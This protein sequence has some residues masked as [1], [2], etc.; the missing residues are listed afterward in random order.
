MSTLKEALENLKAIG[1]TKEMTEEL[2]ELLQPEVRDQVFLDLAGT[3]TEE[4]ISQYEARADTIKTE[5]E[6]TAF[7][8]ELAK[9][10]Y[11]EGYKEKLEQI[12]AE[13]ISNAAELTKNA[14][15]TYQSYMA[16]DPSTVKQVEDAAN[17]EDVQNLVQE[18]NAAGVD[19]KKLATE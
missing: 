18:M 14:R 2:L 3:C 16:G 4:E 12:L 19:W 5:E 7:M 10:A 9:R 11:G 8:D 15:K 13:E 1:Y 6:G 17:S